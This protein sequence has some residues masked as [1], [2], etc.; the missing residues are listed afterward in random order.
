MKRQH[1]SDSDSD[2]EAEVPPAPISSAAMV[3]LACL[4]FG[5]NVAADKRIPGTDIWLGSLSNFTEVDR[6]ELPKGF[7]L[8]LKKAGL[9][10]RFMCREAG[11]QA[12]L[13][14][15]PGF[16]SS[17]NNSKMI[18]RLKPRGG[19]FL[20][21]ADPMQTMLGIFGV[22]SKHKGL[23]GGGRAGRQPTKAMQIK[24]N[25]AI[26]KRRRNKQD[27]GLAAKFASNPA[28]LDHLGLRRVAPSREE[29]DA[30]ETYMGLMA[31]VQAAHASQ[32]ATCRAR[33]LATGDAHLVEQACRGMG[34]PWTGGPGGG[35]F[36]SPTL[37]SSSCV[38]LTM[39]VPAFRKLERHLQHA[40][41]RRPSGG[42][43]AGAAAGH[44]GQAGRA[45]P[46]LRVPGECVGMS[47]R[48][49]HARRGAWTLWD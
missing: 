48:I 11:Y 17:S 22:G 32:S 8:I 26:A 25:H 1:E 41:P 24:D 18:E 45:L 15:S 31:G 34:G 16:F 36:C 49:A 10:L 30:A 6:E 4:E 33:L 42:E 40:G 23:A 47:M 7:R 5:S 35:A 20:P 2:A 29:P 21:G 12:M 28:R 38:G 19:F 14:S 13:C 43:L 37:R 46:K 44:G 27:F 9:K 3:A 39:R